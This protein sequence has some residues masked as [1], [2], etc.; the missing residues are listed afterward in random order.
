MTLQ[1]KYKP[2]IDLANY[3]GVSNFDVRQ[4]GNV[5]HV[6]GTASNSDIKQRLLDAY[7]SIDPGMR[8]GDLKLNIDVAGGEEFYTVQSGDTLSK[9]AAGYQGVTWQ[10]IFEANRDQ[11]Q[12]PDKISPGQKLRIPRA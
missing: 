2:L 7:N 9:I 12:D 3:A 5:L 10:Q 8:A 6:T 11:L 4:E 1:E